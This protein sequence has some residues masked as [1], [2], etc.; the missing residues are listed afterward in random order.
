MNAQLQH[1]TRLPQMRSPYFKQWM[2]A[3]RETL[4]CRVTYTSELDASRTSPKGGSVIFT[5]GLC[6]SREPFTSNRKCNQ[7]DPASLG[8]GPASIV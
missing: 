8:W 6:H 5:H 4:Y 2:N 3:I 1:P 7:A